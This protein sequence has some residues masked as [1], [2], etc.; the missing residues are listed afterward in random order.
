[1]SSRKLFCPA[2]VDRG[3]ESLS[4]SI[5]EAEFEKCAQTF[6]EMALMTSEHQA[7]LLEAA[8]TMSDTILVSEDL[9]DKLSLSEPHKD[10]I[11]RTRGPEEQARTL[12]EIV[13]R[14]PDT[15]FT[16]LVNALRETRQHQVAQFLD[17]YRLET[18]DGHD[19]FVTGT[20]SRDGDEDVT[21]AAYTGK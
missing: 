21:A 19:L 7:A 4:L 10:T 11:R 20:E 6:R 9:L 17:N 2:Y 16:Q 12:L 13:S 1:M 18:A 5:D 3:L 14:R 15:T 8:E